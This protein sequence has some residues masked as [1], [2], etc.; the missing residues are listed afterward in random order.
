MTSQSERPKRTLTDKLPQLKNDSDKSIKKTAAWLKQKVL[1][2]IKT[3]LTRSQ[4]QAQHSLAIDDSTSQRPG[5]PPECLPKNT[6]TPLHDNKP[7]PKAEEQAYNESFHSLDGT[8]LPKAESPLL[9]HNQTTKASHGSIISPQP[10]QSPIERPRST[11]DNSQRA[12][13]KGKPERAPESPAQE[14][15]FFPDK[16]LTELLPGGSQPSPT[17]SAIASLKT[18]VTDSF[19]DNLPRTDPA[20]TITKLNS[21]LLIAQQD[22]QKTKQ[23]SA[24]ITKEM[25]TKQQEHALTLADLERTRA[26]L[27]KLKEDITQL[28]QNTNPPHT[29]IHYFRGWKNTLSTHHPCVLKIGDNYFR[30]QEHAYCYKK[31]MQHHKIDEAEV[32]KKKRFAGN[33]KSYTHSVV[34]NPSEEWESGKG[35]LM[36]T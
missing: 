26:Q 5:I 3:R 16:S 21:L 14:E 13:Q 4:S 34:P 22:L 20:Q 25:G 27:N 24:N 23:T 30:T 32:M 1:T 8:L 31:L 17:R 15:P 12:T 19:I 2:P 35:Q 18:L 11:P 10:S 33:A 7:K 36:Q 29:P 6:S 9:Q 28:R